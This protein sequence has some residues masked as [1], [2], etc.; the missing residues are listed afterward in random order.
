MSPGAEAGHGQV[1]E[2][3]HTPGTKKGVGQNR[4]DP[5]PVTAEKSDG[6]SQWFHC[7]GSMAEDPVNLLTFSAQSYEPQ[8]PVPEKR[9][10][11]QRVEEKECRS[12]CFPFCT[13]T[14]DRHTA[15][16]P[17]IYL[18]SLRHLCGDEE[19]KIKGA[20]VKST[21]LIDHQSLTMQCVLLTFY[22]QTR[23]LLVTY[24]NMASLSIYPRQLPLIQIG[25]HING[26]E[27]KTRQFVS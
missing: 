13:A 15:C 11:L 12:W 6:K 25:P 24:L 22:M 2:Q 5:D 10:G 9:P 19:A 16:F 14:E 27:G 7:S 20:T 4:V 3:T 18:L 23:R 1:M 26:S 8:K 17:V 21:L